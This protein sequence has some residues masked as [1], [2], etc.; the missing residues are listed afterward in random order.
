MNKLKAALVAITLIFGGML[1]APVPAAQAA[2]CTYARVMVYNSPTYQTHSI[3]FNLVG[4]S[5]TNVKTYERL[6][7]GVPVATV[8]TTSSNYT[9]SGTAVGASIFG[10]APLTPNTTYRVTAPGCVRIIDPPDGVPGVTY[11]NKLI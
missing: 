8:V 4:Q 10:D 6:E 3:G 11:Y 5:S 9:F 7:S 2:G 1:I